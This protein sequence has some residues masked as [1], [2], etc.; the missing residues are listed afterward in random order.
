MER[1]TNKCPGDCSKC[2]M[3]AAGQVDMVPCILDQMFTRIQRIEASMT[4][5]TEQR[6]ASVD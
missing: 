1:L 6:L 2:D 5:T 4:T 3:L